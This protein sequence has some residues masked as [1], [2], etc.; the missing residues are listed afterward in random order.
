MAH[1]KLIY[2]FV[3]PLIC[4]AD[5]ALTQFLDLSLFLFRA[6]IELRFV[7]QVAVRVSG[8]VLTL[9]HA[10]V[11]CI[12]A[13]LRSTKMTAAHVTVENLT[14]INAVGGRFY[15]EYTNIK[16]LSEIGADTIPSV[17]QVRRRQLVS[18]HLSKWKSGCAQVQQGE[19]RPRQAANLAQVRLLHVSPSPEPALFGL[20]LLV[21]QPLGAT[22]GLRVAEALVGVLSARVAPGLQQAWRQACAEGE[23]GLFCQCFL[24]VCMPRII[25]FSYNGCGVCSRCISVRVAAD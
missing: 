24:F 2:R 13:W 14:I 6:A 20:P 3:R 1:N 17:F 19:D 25:F 18:L 21:N 10:L 7:F 4:Y 11:P 23:S 12:N 5:Q 22:P 8:T 9:K 15:N 16:L